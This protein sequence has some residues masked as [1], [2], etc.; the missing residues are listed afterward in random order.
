MQQHMQDQEVMITV[1]PD[2]I[3]LQL[4]CSPGRSIWALVFSAACFSGGACQCRGHKRCRL[5]TWVGKI[6]WKRSGNPLQHACL[7]NLADRE[8]WRTTVYAGSHSSLNGCSLGLQ[9]SQQPQIHHLCPI[10]DQGACTGGRQ[11]T[12][13]PALKGIYLITRHQ[14]S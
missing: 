7:E 9:K 11:D 1:Y 13:A 3:P 6:P 12:L 4:S 8:A 5:N 14:V 10:L 2:A